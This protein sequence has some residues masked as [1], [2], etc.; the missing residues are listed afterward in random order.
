M[1]KSIR[2]LHYLFIYLQLFD[3]LCGIGTHPV[4]IFISVAQGTGTSSAGDLQRFAG[5]VTTS[6]V[7][8]LSQ[9]QDIKHHTQGQLATTP[10]RNQTE[11]LSARPA[12]IGMTD[13]LPDGEQMLGLFTNINQ[14][15]AAI[16]ILENGQMANLS[17]N[18]FRWVSSFSTDCI[19]ERVFIWRERREEGNVLHLLITVLLL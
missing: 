17:T 18:K 1:R 7:S 10:H 5:T 16:G 6:K 9:L 12:A 4:F 13:G 14:S 19:Y 2:Y 3:A 8:N 11:Y 15:N